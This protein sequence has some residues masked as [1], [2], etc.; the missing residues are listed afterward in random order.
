[1]RRLLAQ[2]LLVLGLPV[3]VLLATSVPAAACSTADLTLAQQ[4]RQDY[5]FV[6]TVKDVDRAAPDGVRTATYAVEVQHW[7]RGTLPEQVQVSSPVARAECGLQKI[8]TG[9]TYL[10]VADT[11]DS[12]GR[13]QALSFEGTRV[14]TDRIEQRI[15]RLLGEQPKAPV[16][17]DDL[18]E[19]PA[20]PVPTPLDDSAPPKVVEAVTPAALVVLFGAVIFAAGAFLGRRGS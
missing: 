8:Q 18:A 1:M 17:Q 3:G 16:S 10:F 15:S 2:L 11:A 4:L 5:L 13:L 7:W 14:A 12:A 6:G 20:A 19:E 9:T